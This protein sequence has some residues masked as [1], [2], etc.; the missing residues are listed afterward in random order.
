MSQKRIIDA[1]KSWGVVRQQDQMHGG[2]V[3]NRMMQQQPMQQMPQRQ[4]IHPMQQQIMQQP[5]MKQK[6]PMQQQQVPR[7]MVRQQQIPN[8]TVNVNPHANIIYQDTAQQVQE[9]QPEQSQ[10]VYK[11]QPVK[12]HKDSKLLIYDP[13]MRNFDLAGCKTIEDVYNKNADK[14]KIVPE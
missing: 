12:D 4:P 3:N 14:I 10:Q 2:S 11:A 13:E 1:S 8:Y 5:M 9:P 7:Q 6:M